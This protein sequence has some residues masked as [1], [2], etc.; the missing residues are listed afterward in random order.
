VSKK[1]I[2]IIFILVVGMVGGIF[3]SQILMPR[4]LGEGL[5]DSNYLA[6]ITSGPVYLTEKK[7]ITVEE[8]TALQYSIEKV[9]D[10]I[11]GVRTSTLTGKTIYGSGLVLTTDGM[12]VTLAEL[13]PQKGDFTFYIDGKAQTYQILKRDTKNNL[14]LIKI[15]RNDLKPCGFANFSELKVGGRVFLLGKVFLEKDI[16]T[17]ANQGIIKYFTKD[18]IRTSIFEKTSLAGSSLFN[19]KG[20]L[21]GLNT[22]DSEGKVSA[23]PISIIRDFAGF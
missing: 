8:N 15:S 4:F 12:V 17:L 9:E 19:I 1:I 18:F 6:R 14:A 5:F 21:L 11:I 3:S 7:D 23:I 2:N 10:S 20:E 16:L 22:I 13:V